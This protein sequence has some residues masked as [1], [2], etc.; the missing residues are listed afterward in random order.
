MTDFTA[1]TTYSPFKEKPYELN[2]FVIDF[3]C[4]LIGNACGK[5]MVL[6]IFSKVDGSCI[7]KC[8]CEENFM[9]NDTE[10]IQCVLN[11]DSG[12]HYSTVSFSFLILNGIRRRFQKKMN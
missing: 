4:S 11:K 3:D 12:N 5:N 6:Q 7:H 1:F 2:K 9:E 10:C 8:V